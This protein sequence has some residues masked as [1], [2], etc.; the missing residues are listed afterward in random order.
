M[1]YLFSTWMFAAEAA[2]V[3]EQHQ[4]RLVVMFEVWFLPRL[5]DLWRWGKVWQRIVTAVRLH[6]RL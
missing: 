4:M 2:C 1:L 3:K 5:K 6:G